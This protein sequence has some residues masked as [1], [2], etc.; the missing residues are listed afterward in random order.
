[1]NHPLSQFMYICLNVAVFVAAVFLLITM[2]T[3]TND[4]EKVLLDD[5]GERASITMQSIDVKDSIKNSYISSSSVYNN[6][7]STIDLYTEEELE[8]GIIIIVVKGVTLTPE[9]MKSIKERNPEAIK[10]LKTLVNTYSEYRSI[11]EYNDDLV[12]KKII[13]EGV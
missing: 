10:D 6:V 8:S 11:Y 3:F 7:I 9:N 5:M 12:I 1:M 4:R 13:F 2:L